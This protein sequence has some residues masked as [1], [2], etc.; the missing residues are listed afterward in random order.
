MIN[1]NYNKGFTLIELLVVISIIGLLSSIVL[2]SLSTTRVR[3]S[4][5]AIKADLRGI[6]TS[7]EVEYAT[8][9][10]SYNNSNQAVSLDCT[11]TCTAAN[12]ILQNQRI[13]DAIKHIVANNGGQAVTVSIPLDGKSYTISAPL[14]TPNTQVSVDSANGGNI[15][16]GLITPEA[17]TNLS[18]VWGST[19]NSFA[20]VIISWSDNINTGS[21]T[22]R[23]ERSLNS[24]G[25]F[26]VYTSLPSTLG[27]VTDFTVGP[28]FMFNGLYFWRIRVQKGTKY[29]AYS[30]IFQLNAF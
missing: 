1:I 18:V 20:P 3:A 24:N 12:T 23:I 15:S 4:D 9:G 7:A 27:T 22:Y 10:Y 5:A 16:L 25:P 19:A 13:Q 6:A 2:A 8:L 29:S 11:T 21:V 28:N 30:P 26:T 14:K 17:P